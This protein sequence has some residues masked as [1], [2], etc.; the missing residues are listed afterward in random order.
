ML[1]KNEILGKNLLNKRKVFIEGWGGEVYLQELSAKRVIEIQSKDQ[2][3]KDDL[4]AKLELY[5]EV[6][7][8]CIFD[9]DNNQVFDKDSIQELIE[10]SDFGFIADL[11]NKILLQD[12]K[13]ESKK[14]S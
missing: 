4:K 14:K 1:K 2:E 10:N 9:E 8:D 5:G 3:I 6:I 7:I 13:E 12:I 11:I